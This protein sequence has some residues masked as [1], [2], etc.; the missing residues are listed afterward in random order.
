ME[1]WSNAHFNGNNGLVIP[2]D[3]NRTGLVKFVYDDLQEQ[4]IKD[5][6]KTTYPDITKIELFKRD[7]EFTGMI[8]VVFKEEA[9]LN[10]VI[11]ERFKLCHKKYIIEAFKQKPRVIKCNTCQRFG[12]VSRLCRSKANPICGKCS[13]EG[14]ETKD[15]T[16][17]ENEIKCF[18]CGKNDH[19]TGSYSCEKIQEKLQELLDRQDGY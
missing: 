2:A 15:C 8:K 17:E 10:R 4:E 9:Q 18:H 6:I 7:E 3:K 5:D 12:H 14:H 16:A 19:I 1:E 11:A 13:M